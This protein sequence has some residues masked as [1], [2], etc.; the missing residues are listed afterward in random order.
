MII[1]FLEKNSYK[2]LKKIEINRNIVFR[3]G[4]GPIFVI[5][6]IKNSQKIFFLDIY[7][8][9]YKILKKFELKNCK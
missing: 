7:Y 3:N 9:N 8:I 1:L 4:K 2:F 5:F 6:L